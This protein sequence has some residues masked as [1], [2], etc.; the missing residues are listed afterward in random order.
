MADFTLSDACVGILAELY[1]N[2]SQQSRSTPELQED[3]KYLIDVGLI[4]EFQRDMVWWGMVWL[5]RATERG[6]DVLKQEID[7]LRVFSL[8]LTT[9][10]TIKG[11]CTWVMMFDLAQLPVA[12]A[13]SDAEIRDAA[14]VRLMQIENRIELSD[15]ELM[16]LM[17]CYRAVIERP[18]DWVPPRVVRRLI[19]LGLL[20]IT[21]VTPN[22]GWRSG[23]GYAINLTD[24]GTKFLEEHHPVALVEFL[25]GCLD[26]GPELPTLRDSY[27]VN[28]LLKLFKALPA[29]HLVE[30]LVAE[31][32]FIRGHAIRRLEQLSGSRP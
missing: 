28:R 2:G 12:F 22:S 11:A 27:H 18:S 4:E 24:E 32:E 1:W 6:V 3:I 16:R 19:L 25:V 5:V 15:D 8:F 20:N 29:R 31:N 30:L 7:P 13:H 23:V 21:S 14:E 26:G 10:K 9:I 17:L